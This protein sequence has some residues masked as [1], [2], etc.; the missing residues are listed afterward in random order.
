MTYNQ[1]E[2]RTI[3]EAVAPLIAAAAVRASGTPGERTTVT[4]VNDAWAQLVKA[5]SEFDR[6]G[7]R[8]GSQG[9]LRDEHKRLSKSERNDAALAADAVMEAAEAVERIARESL[10]A[11]TTEAGGLIG[12]VIRA[13]K[14][15]SLMLEVMRILIRPTTRSD[16]P[17]VIA[18]LV[19]QANYLAGISPDPNCVVQQDHSERDFWSLPAIRDWEQRR[20][21]PVEQAGEAS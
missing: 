5:L 19:F 20:R 9:H 4:P 16:S 12:L 18:A 21:S 2:M 14:I 10:D 13:S 7:L 11:A 15:R 6:L 17:A 8:V 3:K 1:L